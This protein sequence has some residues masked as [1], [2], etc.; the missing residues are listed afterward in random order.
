MAAATVLADTVYRAATG[1]RDARSIARIAR[2]LVPVVA[3]IALW[4]TFRGGSTIVALLL[5]GYAFVTQ[6]FPAAVFSLGR[7]RRSA[8]SVGIGICVGV[9]I[10]SWTT[11]T[12]A[13]FGQLAP[14]LPSA[15]TDMNIGILALTGNIV[16]LTAVDFVLRARK[17]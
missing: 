13:T 8:T 15:M 7:R 4:F 16:T 17:R 10:V 9:G 3:G 11:L 12:G 1:E 2:G 5:M 14:S 6:L